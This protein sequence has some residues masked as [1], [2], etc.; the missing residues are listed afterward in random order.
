MSDISS[1]PVFEF[2]GV[3]KSYQMGESTV[4][5]LNE[6]DLQVREG[7]FL[8]ILGPSGSGK[9]TLMHI[10]GCMDQPSAGEVLLDGEDVAKVS[11]SKLARV[12]RSKV[13]FVFQTF[14]LL[15]KLS[16]L[17]NVMLPMLYCH[18]KRADARKRAAEVLEMVGLSDRVGHMPG[19][20][21]GG[22][23]QR[24]AIARSLVN[25]PRVILADEPTGN[26][27]TASARRVLELFGELHERGRTVVL[28]THDPRVADVAH[29]T[30]VVEDGRVSESGALTSFVG[31]VK[32]SDGKEVR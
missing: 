32:E 5:A 23:R 17:E 25:D 24:V 9:S 31:M 18:R 16:V 13:G 12:R 4:Y 28:V 8:A 15:P 21:S 6:V 26:L 20:L 7:E 22:Q 11:A 19:Q 3:S 29:R 14:N 27:D 10:M 2:R 1:E 30:I